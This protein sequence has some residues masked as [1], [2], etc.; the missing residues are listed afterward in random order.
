MTE[1]EIKDANRSMINEL[2]EHTGQL[3]VKTNLPPMTKRAKLTTDKINADLG[4]Q[5]KYDH[6]LLPAPLI[7][8]ITGWSSGARYLRDKHGVKVGEM[9]LTT[10]DKVADIEAEIQA[11]NEEKDKIIAHTEANWGVVMNFVQATL[12]NLDDE[13]MRLYGT[14]QGLQTFKNGF[15]FKAQVLPIPVSGGAAIPASFVGESRAK[16]EEYFKN[17]ESQFV[18]SMA[19][20]ID[21]ELESLGQRF[22]ARVDWYEAGGVKDDEPK[23][24]ITDKFV[25]GINSRVTAVGTVGAGLVPGVTQVAQHWDKVGSQ[26]VEQR[27]AALGTLGSCQQFVQAIGKLRAMLR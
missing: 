10:L 9:Y 6:E 4:A 15:G 12:G 23:P 27:E 2:R 16:A 18:A 26:L 19:Q 11:I 24:R 3:V 8:K 14:Q 1:Q 22:Q 25:R 21:L 7:K 20:A 5:G 13:D 17:H